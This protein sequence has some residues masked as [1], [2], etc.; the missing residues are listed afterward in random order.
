MPSRVAEMT[1]VP[2]FPVEFA[3]KT[4]PAA[5]IAMAVFDEFHVTICVMSKLPLPL[6]PFAVK[7]SVPPCG[8]VVP[9]PVIVMEVRFGG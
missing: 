9:E 5:I 3:V 8:A 4:P 1:V 2:P 6:I 7:F